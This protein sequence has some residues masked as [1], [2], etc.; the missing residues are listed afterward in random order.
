LFVADIESCDIESINT[1]TNVKDLDHICLTVAPQ[2]D[3][4]QA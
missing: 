2:T 4:P 1:C 3:A